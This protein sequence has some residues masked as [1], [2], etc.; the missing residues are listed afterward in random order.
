MCSKL[1]NNEI[2]YEG[3]LEGNKEW[4]AATLQ[5][6][7]TYFERLAAG[8]KP[9]VLW[10][11]C[12]D[13]RVPA[14]QITNTNPG[15]IFVHRNIA[16]VVVHT[17]MNMLSVLDYAVNVLEVE[18]VIVCGH[19]GCGGVQ[20][21]LGNKQYGIIDNW[22]RNIKDTYRLH[23]Y[24]L[25]LISNEKKR[26]DRLVELNVIEGVFNLTKTSIVQNR[27]ANGKTLGVHGWV[28]SLETG[29]IKDLEVTSESNDLISSVFKMDNQ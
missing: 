24:E 3:L 11:G 6:D 7:P 14:N 25:D 9:P 8:Q 28:Y 1:S 17:D 29:L 16:N 19:Y 13:S 22:L 20:A 18:H 10:I 12:S 27:W 4:V 26:F 15:D 21:A 5:E 2:T 23:N